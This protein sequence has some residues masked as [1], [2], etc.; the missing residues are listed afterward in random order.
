MKILKGTPA[1][2]FEEI[3]DF[4]FTSLVKTD[5]GFMVSNDKEMLRIQMSK[6][7]MEALKNILKE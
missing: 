6:K 5:E 2:K 7:E 1:T 3:V 4:E